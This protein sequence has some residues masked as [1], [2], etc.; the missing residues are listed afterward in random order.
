MAYW[1]CWQHRYLTLLMTH[2]SLLTIHLYWQHCYDWQVNFLFYVCITKAIPSEWKQKLKGKT[3]TDIGLEG[4][5]GI[6]G[7]PGDFLN[8]DNKVIYSALVLKKLDGLKAHN[9]LTDQYGLTEKEWKLIYSLSHNIKLS[10]KS[11]EIF[12]F[13]PCISLYFYPSLLYDNQLELKYSEG[14]T[15]SLY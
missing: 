1:K 3:K 15:N 5:I 14:F 10:N 13:S 2:L 9:R 8:V 6:N 7:I 12:V 11:K 4:L